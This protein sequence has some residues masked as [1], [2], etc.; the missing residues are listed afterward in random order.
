VVDDTGLHTTARPIEARPHPRRLR[1]NPTQ[2]NRAR[3]A[4][5]MDG[6]MRAVCMAMAGHILQSLASSS[7]PALLGGGDIDS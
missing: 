2:C 6:W 4:G 1:A 7:R 5:T 3:P